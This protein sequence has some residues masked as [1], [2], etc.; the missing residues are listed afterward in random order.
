MSLLVKSYQDLA[1]TVAGDEKVIELQSY[2]I[3]TLKGGGIFSAVDNSLPAIE[4]FRIKTRDGKTFQRQYAE[5]VQPSLLL[6]DLGWTP[7]YNEDA[8]EL[9][10]KLFTLASR[11]GVKAEFPKSAIIRVSNFIKIPKGL[12]AIEGNNSFLFF[13]FN[14]NKEAGLISD[15]G[16]TGLTIKALHIDHDRVDERLERVIALWYIDQTDC[17]LFDC[18][19]NSKENHSV[20]CRTS[21]DAKEASK[22]F[23]MKNVVMFTNKKV[24]DDPRQNFVADVDGTVAAT[25]NWLE[26]FNSPDKKGHEDYIIEDCEAWGGRYGYGLNWATGFTM[27]NVLGWGNMRT[28]STQNDCYRNTYDGIISLQTKSAPIHFGYETGENHVKNSKVMTSVGDG[29][30]LIHFNLGS[31]NNIVENT[32]LENTSPTGQRWGIYLGGNLDGNVI[33]DVTLKSNFYEVGLMIESDWI[34]NFGY[35]GTISRTSP[36]APHV[37][38]P[39]TNTKIQNL[40]IDSESRS[41]AIQLHSGKQGL[42]GVILD[43]VKVLGKNHSKDLDIVETEGG[44][45]CN[46][47]FRNLSVNPDKCNFGRIDMYREFQRV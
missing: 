32:Y 16:I 6:E 42:D 11:A 35:G 41:P 9:V 39:S 23:H 2:N 47:T 10:G 31:Y 8:T 7:A 30:G 24:F 21:K 17:K 1:T 3:N 38:K 13:Y 36:I 40:V 5:N 26:N 25:A 27:K 29:Q 28:V 19:I 44:K 43:N 12:K 37:N 22:R 20:L 15:S 46:F 14:G 45:A 18:N 33:K 4:G 34:M